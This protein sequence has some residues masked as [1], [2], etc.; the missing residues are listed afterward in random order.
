MKRAAY[1]TIQLIDAIAADYISDGPIVIETRFDEFNLD[2]RLTYQ[3]E[4]L[5]FP[6]Q[7]SA[8]ADIR[9]SEAGARLIAGFMLRR[10]ADRTRSEWKGGRAR[11]LFHFDH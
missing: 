4:R 9:E 7:R 11:V 5:A 6:D 8:L 2:V 3:D 10:N 1:G